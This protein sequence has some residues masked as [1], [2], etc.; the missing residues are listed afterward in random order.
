MGVAVVDVTTGLFACNA[1]LVALHHRSQTGRGQYIDV[2]LL[3]SQVAWLINVAH[4]YFATGKTPQ[5]YGNAH[6]SIVPY[7]TFPTADGHIAVGIGSDEQYRRLCRAMAGGF[8][9]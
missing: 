3:D 5:R 8:G 9:R 1:I 6:A 4:N 2:A 7:E